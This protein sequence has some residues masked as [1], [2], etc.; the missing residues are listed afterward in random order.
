MVI[1]AFD[2]SV[3]A[4]TLISPPHMQLHQ[5]SIKSDTDIADCQK[6]PNKPKEKIKKKKNA[7]EEQNK[8]NTTMRLGTTTE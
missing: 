6:V 4:S 7:E 2:L 8:I 3:V 1:H 5:D